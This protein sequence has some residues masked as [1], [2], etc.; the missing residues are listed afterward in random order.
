MNTVAGRIIQTSRLSME[1]ITVYP[2]QTLDWT[3]FH[4]LNSSLMLSLHEDRVLH[5]I[6]KTWSAHGSCQL[7]IP[8]ELA[9][10]HNLLD[11]NVIIEDTGK[12]LLLKKLELND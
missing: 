12:G 1:K 4:Y 11:A 2:Y 9:V 3:L 10:K 8:K 5:E 6:S 7:V